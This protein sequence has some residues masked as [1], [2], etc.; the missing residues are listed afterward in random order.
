[1]RGK[2]TFFIIANL[3]IIFRITSPYLA[4]ILLTS[5]F[6][7]LFDALP[8]KLATIPPRIVASN[9]EVSNLSVHCFCYLKENV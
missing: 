2:P 4:F 5:L 1:M 9:G 6:G 3:I 8:S 7:A